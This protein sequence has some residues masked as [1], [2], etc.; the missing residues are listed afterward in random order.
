MIRIRAN[1]ARSL[2][3]AQCCLLSGVMPACAPIELIS[4][5]GPDAAYTAAE[6]RSADDVWDDNKLKLALNQAFLDHSVGLF[7]D[8]GTVVYE[9]RVLLVGSVDD[10]R[11]RALAEQIARRQEGV[12]SVTNRIQVTD[13][14]GLIAYGK[15]IIVEKQI[16]AALLFDETVASSNLRVRSVNLIVY[17]F[18]AAANQQ[19]IDRTMTIVRDVDGLRGIENL[20]WIRGQI[21]G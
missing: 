2:L 1:P 12:K 9:R 14:G 6:D 3:L 17:L 15:D 13:A 18:G 8:I 4:A 21:A 20:L 16:Q 7:A 5:V 10:T 19:E 11:T